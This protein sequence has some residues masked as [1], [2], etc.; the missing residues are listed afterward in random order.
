MR[1]STCRL[2]TGHGTWPAAI[3]ALMSHTGYHVQS[4]PNGLFAPCQ[5]V[6][7]PAQIVDPMRLKRAC[8]QSLR[9]HRRSKGIR[10]GAQYPVW[11]ALSGVKLGAVFQTGGESW[12]SSD[13]GLC[14]WNTNRRRGRAMTGPGSSRA[15][16]RW[17]CRRQ[18][19][20]CIAPKIETL[21]SPA[22]R[23]VRCRQTSSS[24][25][26]AGQSFHTCALYNAAIAHT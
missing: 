3:R 19:R 20:L 2:P 8:R 16:H 9:F 15:C 21:Q 4:M 13:D 14:D 22:C 12:A 6:P 11:I 25:C 10:C 1:P 5:P 18:H 24:V 17:N 7:G 26:R 23:C